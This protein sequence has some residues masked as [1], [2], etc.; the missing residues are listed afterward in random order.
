MSV[1]QPEGNEGKLEGKDA[2][3]PN[4]ADIDELS[5]ITSV[6]EEQ[7][8]KELKEQKSSKKRKNKSRHSASKKV[9]GGD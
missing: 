1:I 2:K 5:D 7:H 8:H 9:K 3:L 6:E 4:A